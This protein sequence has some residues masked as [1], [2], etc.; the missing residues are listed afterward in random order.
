MKKEA[1]PE[2]TQVPILALIYSTFLSLPILGQGVEDPAVPLEQ[3]GD[4]CCCKG[5]CPPQGLSPLQQGILCALGK[6]LVGLGRS[7]RQP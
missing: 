2:I 3:V 4:E 1:G 5:L 6:P 7:C